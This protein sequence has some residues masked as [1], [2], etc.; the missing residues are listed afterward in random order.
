MER[1][2][3]EKF[4]DVVVDKEKL[5]SIRGGGSMNSETCNTQG[6]WLTSDSQTDYYFDDADDG[7]YEYGGYSTTH[8]VVEGGMLR[9]T[10]T[11]YVVI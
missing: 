10:A 6:G 4:K 5:N 7:C 3:L 11:E 2:G 9:K 8:Y 1:I